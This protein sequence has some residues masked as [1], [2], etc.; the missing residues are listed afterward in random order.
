MS[1]AEDTE[2]FHFGRWVGH[3]LLF[4]DVVESDQRAPFV[5]FTVPD[6]ILTFFGVEEGG[7]EFGI[8]APQL[9]F[10]LALGTVSDI[11]DVCSDGCTSP[12]HTMCNATPSSTD[13][14]IGRSLQCMHVV[15]YI[16][17]H[18]SSEEAKHKG[19]GQA[20]GQVY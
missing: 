16:Q 17:I 3:H 14:G 2:P 1:A 11:C 5:T 12:H 4:S 20:R 18:H 10:W 6:A 9:Q 15:H 19:E 8:L 7:N 13:V